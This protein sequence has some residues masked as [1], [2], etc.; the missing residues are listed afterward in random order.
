[1][2]VAVVLRRPEAALTRSG[3]AAGNAIAGA[4][5]TN[6]QW[7]LRQ[8]CTET[9]SVAFFMQQTPLPLSTRSASGRIA[10]GRQQGG[11]ELRFLKLP[12]GV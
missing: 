7:S 4:A 1:M 8:S 11:A 6:P 9:H 2:R 3:A 5:L 10:G 12:C